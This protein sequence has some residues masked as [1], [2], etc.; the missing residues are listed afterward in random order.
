[1]NSYW[2]IGHFSKFVRPGARRVACTVSNDDLRATA[3]VNP[4]G[5]AVAVVLND[6]DRAQ[7]LGL[8]RSGQ[9]ARSTLPAHAIATFT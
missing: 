9:V 6:T 2:Y 7:D 4:D 3:F 8:W 5:R 1:M